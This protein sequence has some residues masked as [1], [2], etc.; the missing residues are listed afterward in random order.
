MEHSGNYNSNETNQTK[1]D[2]ADRRI[3]HT[4]LIRNSYAKTLGENIAWEKVIEEINRPNPYWLKLAQDAQDALAKAGG[5]KKAPKDATP[6]VKALVK[7]YRDAKRNLPAL[8]ISVVDAPAGT[9]REG[10]P[11]DWHSGCYV[12]RPG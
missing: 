7:E 3:T 10:L 11:Y 5:L 6:E 1:E 9:P 4:T 2:P 12:L 8:V